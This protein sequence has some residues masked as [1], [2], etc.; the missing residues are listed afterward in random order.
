MS[1][2][3]SRPAATPDPAPAP[4]RRAGSSDPIPPHAV[5]VGVDGSPSAATA[6]TWAARE[7]ER[8]RAPLHLICS[9]EAYIGVMHQLDGAVTWPLLEDDDS[10]EILADAG[11]LARQV[12]PG[13]SVT[14]AAPYGRPAHHLV[15]ASGE[16]AL[17]VLG[18]RGRGRLTSTVLG[19]TSLQTA[20]HARCPV[21]V[22]RRPDQEHPG[23]GLRV[24]VGVDGSRHSLG[25]VDF[26][27]Q[28]ADPGGSVTLVLAWW[29]EI[30][31]GVVVTTPDSPQWAR[32]ERRHAALLTAALGDNAR[33]RPQV[34]V[35]T[36]AVRSHAAE[37]LLSA[38]ADA[39]LLVVGSRG[40][41]GFAGLL[42]GSVSQQMLVSAPC[43]VAV[44]PHR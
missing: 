6:L 41:G 17:L 34:E 16:A 21:V 14:S 5:V 25:A 31:D 15:E 43:P 23:S 24:V 22:V 13:V 11:D 44:S 38:S 10:Q 30:V 27:M 9:R 28:M 8:R 33:Q 37:A 19:T 40:R 1:P 20:I 7:A 18:S 29:L 26:A 32:A 12:A 35:V 39:D 2:D 42:L 4:D 3:Q 36:K